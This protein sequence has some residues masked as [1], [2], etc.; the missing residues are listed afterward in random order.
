MQKTKVQE[1]PFDM[2]RHYHALSPY[3][4]SHIMKINESQI[5]KSFKKRK[6]EKIQ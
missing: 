5:K 4:I 3:H 6:F 2:F 1:I